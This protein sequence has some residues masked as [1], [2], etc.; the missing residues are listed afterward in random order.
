MTYS[1]ARRNICLAALGA[2][3]TKPA[4]G[5]ADFPSRPLRLIIPFPG[6]FTDTLARVVAQPLSSALGQPVAVEQ[7]PGGSGQIAAGEL[8]R[9]PAD[10]HTMMLI[11][12][13]THALNQA[14]FSKLSY[15]ANADFSPLSE[16]VRLPNLLIASPS[17]GVRSVSELV[18]LARSKPDTLLFASPGNGSSGHLAGEL[19][20]TRASIRVSHV[21]YK[22]ASE[23]VLDLS[24]GRVHFSF[25]TLAQGSALSRA[26]KVTAL[27]VTSPERH[28]AFPDIPTMS[29]S[30]FPGWETGPW[31]GLAARSGTPEPIV[32]RLADEIRRALALPDVQSRLTAMGATPIGSTPQAFRQQ[33]AAE[34]KRWG[35]LIRSI[36]IRVE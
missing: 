4:L 9:A 28:P 20:R 10:G 2:L 1:P 5:Q 25:D 11:H 17:L 33:I 23:S 29:E 32:T 30:G 27:A 13:G 36:G 26:G 22:G 15:D 35:D 14:L 24:A 16:L 6:G 18:E 12:V 8:L 3:A 34:Q 21:P 31:F 19:F 7:K